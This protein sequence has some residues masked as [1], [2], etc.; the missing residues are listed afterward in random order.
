[1]PLFISIRYF[2]NHLLNK[3]HRLLAVAIVGLNFVNP[4]FDDLADVLHSGDSLLQHLVGRTEEVELALQRFGF[5]A[6]LQSASLASLVV[7]LSHFL[8]KKKIPIIKTI[9]ERKNYI[10]TIKCV[11]FFKV[12]QQSAGN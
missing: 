4:V 5:Q 10:N 2:Q 7:S 3:R 12:I 11:A 9:F 1:M 8:M 6:T